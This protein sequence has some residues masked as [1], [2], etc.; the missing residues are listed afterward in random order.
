[1]NYY[2]IEYF[3]DSEVGVTVWKRYR[4][5]AI[6]QADTFESACE[7]IKAQKIH[8]YDRNFLFVDET[9]R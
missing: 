6:V 8:K 3:Y 5:T 1:M 7:K 2:S 9:I 4:S